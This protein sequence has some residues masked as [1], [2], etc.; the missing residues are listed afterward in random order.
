MCL[1]ATDFFRFL[2]NR[3]LLRLGLSFTKIYFKAFVVFRCWGS[4]VLICVASPCV[5]KLFML[6]IAFGFACAAGCE[7]GGSSLNPQRCIFK[8][9]WEFLKIRD[10]IFWGPYNKILLLFR[11]L[12]WGPLFSETPKWMLLLLSRLFIPVGAGGASP[13]FGG[14]ANGSINVGRFGGISES[15]GLRQRRIK[16]CGQHTLKTESLVW[17]VKLSSCVRLQPDPVSLPCQGLPR[18]WKPRT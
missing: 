13:L 11:V 8:L 15:S 14:G 6:R 4:P 17:K 7:W 16:A 2:F 1:I 12:Y 18:W 10:T 5:A 9:K 3:F